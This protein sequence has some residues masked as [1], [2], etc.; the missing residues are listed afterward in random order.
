MINR[1]FRSSLISLGVY[2][3]VSLATARERR[4]EA[5]K[6]LAAGIDPSAKR[7]AEKL[8]LA[9]TFKAVAEEFLTKPDFWTKSG[10]A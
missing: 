9:D 8:A 1:F 5:R 3:E 2:P 10:S 6:L 7:R 4:D